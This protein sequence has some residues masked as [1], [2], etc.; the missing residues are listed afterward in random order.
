MVP[1]LPLDFSHSPV[2]SLVLRA[3]PKR[4]GEQG[5]GILG[6]VGLQSFGTTKR[7]LSGVGQSRI[8][9][10]PSQASAAHSAAYQNWR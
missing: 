9:L 3:T 7:I 10:R 5:F 2:G 6:L 4:L 8:A 1:P